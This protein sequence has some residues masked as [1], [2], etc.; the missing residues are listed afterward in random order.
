MRQYYFIASV[1]VV[2]ETAPRLLSK[3]TSLCKR[4][5]GATKEGEAGENKVGRRGCLRSYERPPLTG[6]VPRKTGKLCAARGDAF[7]LPVVS[8][9]LIGEKPR[10]VG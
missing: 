9:C 2:L 4:S 1:S 7:C 5:L 8:T 10:V 6:D 3:S